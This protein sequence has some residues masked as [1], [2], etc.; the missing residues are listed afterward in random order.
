[1]RTAGNRRGTDVAGAVN[2]AWTDG[3]TVGIVTSSVTLP[4]EESDLAGWVESLDDTALATVL[5]V[6]RAV[7]SQRTIDAGDTDA[8]VELG[9]A[10]GFTRDGVARDP[11]IVSGLVVCPGSHQD[12]SATSHDCTFVAIDDDWVWDSPGAVADSVRRISGPRQS[13]RTVSVVAPADGMGIDLVTSRMR[14][15]VH[16]MRSVR[17][18]TFEAGE[19]TLVATRARKPENHRGR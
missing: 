3:G 16:Q 15:G 8:L 17:S 2:A 14:T 19:L 9:F 18:F 10:E 6:A 12:R 4:D 11:W 7:S 5:R 1:M 13:M